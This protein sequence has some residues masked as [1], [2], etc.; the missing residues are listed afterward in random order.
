MAYATI[1]DIRDEGFSIAEISDER[2]RRAL[3]EASAMIDAVTGQFF[4]PRALSLVLEGRG[5]PSLWLPVPILRLDSLVV[6][7]APWSTD[8]DDLA[9]VGGPVTPGADGPRLTRHWGVFPRGA[10]IRVEGLWG[11]TEPDGTPRGRT[12]LAIRRACLLLLT[13]LAS[14]LANDASTDARTQWRIV[15]ERT[16]DQSIRLADPSARAPVLTGDA[17]IDG[18]LW[19]YTRRPGFGAA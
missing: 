16:R 11:Y 1:E 13:R 8:E 2:A 10:S 17:E 18:L 15:E 3:D 12:P 19:P 7:G 6:Q 9:I 14:P 4:A 5:A